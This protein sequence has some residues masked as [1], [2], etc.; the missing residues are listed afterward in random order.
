MCDRIPLK[1]SK[2]VQIAKV[3]ELNMDHMA[4]AP[5]KLLPVL[6]QLL[7]PVFSLPQWEFL[8]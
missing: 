4:F 3:S 7:K 1:Q 2:E 5:F 8:H 6:L